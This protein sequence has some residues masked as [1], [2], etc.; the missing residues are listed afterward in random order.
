MASKRLL[1]AAALLAAVA[2]AVLFPAGAL[3]AGNDVGKNVGELLR[4][5][6]SQLY[7]GVIAVISLMFLLNRR[8]TELA[9]F[10]LASIVV[11]WMV[12]APE[13]IAKAAETIGHQVF[14]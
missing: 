12:F 5:Y 2:L 7:G 6:A 13:E 8:Y 11:A 3:A 4:H 14:G 10:L 1:C 9:V